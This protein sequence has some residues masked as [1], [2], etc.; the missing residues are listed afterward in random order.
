MFR[1]ALRSL[2]FRKVGFVSSFI[3]LFFGAAIV[4][5]CGGL[6]ETGIR[7]AVPPQR[8][9]AAPVVVAGE[10]SVNLPTDGPLDEDDDQETGNLPERPRVDAGL[11]ARVDALPGVAKAV[12]YNSFPV[13]VLH[14][15]SPVADG[16]ETGYGWASAALAPY[17]LAGGTAPGA[18]EV[19][20]D[21]ALAARAGAGIGD[22]VELAVRGVPERFRLAG[23]ATGG[24]PSIFFGDA[25]TLRFSAER[26]KVDAIGVLAEPGTTDLQSRVDSLVRETGAVTLTG[27]ERGLLEFPAVAAGGETLIVLAGVFGGMATM[28]AVFVVASTLGL[29]VQQ[30]QREMALLRAIGTTPRQLRRMVMG[31]SLVVSVAAVAL[32]CPAGMLLGNWLF[33][34]LAERGVVPAAIVFHQGWIPVA[35]AAGAALLAALGAAYVAARRA[36]RARPTEALA[37]ATGQVRWLSAVRLIFAVLCLGG[38]IA[39][40]IVTMTVMTGPIAAST[41]GPTVMLWAIAFALLAPGVTRVITSLLSVPLRLFAGF[42]GKL[43]LLNAK[44]RRV[45]MAAAITPVMLATGMSISMI[46]LQTTQVSVQEQAFTENLRADAVIASSIGGVAP[47]LVDSV[48]ALPGVAGASG[49][50]TSAGFVQSPYPRWQGDEGLPLQGVSAAGAE[51]T[52]AV[53][54][55]AG[56]LADLRGNSIALPAKYAEGLD[57]GDRIGIQMGDGVPL[58]VELVAVFPARSGFETGLMPASLVAAHTTSGLLPQILVRAAPGVGPEQ[59]TATLSGF[60]AS[61]PGLVVADRD[62]LAAANSEQDQTGAWVNYLLV[63]M[64]VGYTVIALVNTLVLATAERRREFALQRL[65]GSTRA[66]IIRMMSVEAALVA[67]GGILLGTAVA[68]TSLVPFS[69]VVSDSPLPQGPLWIFLAI[70]GFAVTLSAVATLVPTVAAL[71]AHPVEASAAT[72]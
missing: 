67:V 25:D 70:V 21:P 29:S 33:E 68:S 41:A 2:R 15:G 31:E 71:R 14:D 72:D 64:I 20:L 59:L 17:T 69:L 12:P 60:A 35:A 46:Y 9:A 63:A 61:L 32:A 1:L 38:G 7:T 42:P 24:A 30:R 13:A 19:V 53:T 62:A 3:A 55:T 26:G 27:D 11:V 37:D 44:A 10:T 48:A 54:P 50:V 65:I 28:V 6:M 34:R 4:M 45:R 22:Q 36:S 51:Q 16:P 57:I 49:L 8:L 18:H 40:S 47:G 66:Q 52:M 56:S 23:F 43:A 39:L 58:D 5:A